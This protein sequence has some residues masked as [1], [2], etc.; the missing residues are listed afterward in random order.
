[1]NDVVEA[2]QGSRPST[3]VVV[4]GATSGIGRETA[5]RF[6]AL[7]AAVVL[8]AR[9]DAALRRT[10]ADCRHAGAAA[11]VECLTD[12]RD[13][14]EVDQLIEAAVARFGRLDVVVQA[15]AVAV[16]GEFLDVPGE[17][18]EAVVRTNLFGSANVA[19]AALGQFR[20]QGTGHLVLVGSVLGQVAVPYM[21]GYVVSK[22]AVQGLVRALRQ[23]NRELPGVRV[24][25]VYPGPVD[26]P[27]YGNA[28]NYQ[29][30]KA[31]VL[32]G[33]DGPATV[34]AAIVRAT[35]RGGHSER[36]VGW[37]NRALLAANLLLP[38]LLDAMVAPAMRTVS[39]TR[40]AW[41]ATSGNVFEPPPAAPELQ[42][43]GAGVDGRSRGL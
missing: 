30:R 32:P 25:G 40:Q 43:R 35:R 22:F 14:H 13:R 5:L 12:V 34:A 38:R 3:V 7:G 26:T 17:V 21:S 1:M 42:Y 41:A 24:H 19:R 9:S 6:A 33:A 16:F 23:E 4:V 37:S 8:A 2:Q 20:T 29:G 11:V 39:F 18:F 36:Q 28:A 31:R 15:A 10:A 27:I